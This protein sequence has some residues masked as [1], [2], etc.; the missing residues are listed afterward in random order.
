MGSPDP[1]VQASGTLGMPA[2]LARSNSRPQLKR[3]NMPIGIRTILVVCC[4]L[5]VTACSATA[6]SPTGGGGN[7]GILNQLV[8][9]P[10]PADWI[11]VT[12]PAGTAVLSYPPSFTPVRT[13]P[14][15][16]SVATGAGSPIYQGYLNVTPRQGAET[17]RGFTAFRLDHLGDEDTNVHEI[18]SAGR[19]AFQG[20]V[21][22][23]VN[24][25][26]RTRVGHNHYE[27]IA[28]FVAGADDEYVVVAAALYA[29]WGRLAPTL[30]EA[31][32]GFEAG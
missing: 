15:T 9:G 26:Y 28:C 1:V 5:V 22:S 31:V 18:T 6:A 11:R 8:P 32:E 4:A 10:A 3:F 12:T 24:D 19:V 23:C 27:E 30:R 16:V 29:D 14:G 2:E 17:L 20:A 7:S 21:G 13:D 25:D